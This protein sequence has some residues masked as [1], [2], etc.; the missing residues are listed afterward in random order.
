MKSAIAEAL[1]NKARARKGV[2]AKIVGSAS[3]KVESESYFLPGVAHAAPVI[4]LGSDLA[5]ISTP[6]DFHPTRSA[7]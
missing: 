3:P 7:K 5:F 4:L 1:K 2:T 6:A